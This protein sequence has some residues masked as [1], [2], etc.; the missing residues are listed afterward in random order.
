MDIV[1]RLQAWM[2]G[3]ITRE[4]IRAQLSEMNPQHQYYMSNGDGNMI[5]DEQ[6]QHLNDQDMQNLKDIDESQLEERD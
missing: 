6:Y 1:V 5:M 2:R 3:V 4:R